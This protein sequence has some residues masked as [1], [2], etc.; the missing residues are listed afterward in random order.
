MKASAAFW[1][2]SAVSMGKSVISY[3][4][5]VKDY[6]AANTDD[7][8]EQDI[9]AVLG[10]FYQ[11]ELIKG[12]MAKFGRPDELLSYLGYMD[13]WAYKDCRFKIFCQYE[14]VAGIYKIIKERCAVNSIDQSKL[15]QFS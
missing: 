1:Q 8:G 10:N 4:K 9:V 7:L 2:G 5:C 11:P 3:Y 13:C 12:V 15:L 14:S 6:I